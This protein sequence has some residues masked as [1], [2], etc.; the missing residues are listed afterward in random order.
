MVYG[1]NADHLVDMEEGSGFDVFLPTGMLEASLAGRLNTDSVD[2]SRERRV[3]PGLI[4]RP[5]TLFTDELMQILY[6]NVDQERYAKGAKL[7]TS[8]T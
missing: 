8:K 5:N 7:E 2:F 4:L 1:Q 6:D 3:T